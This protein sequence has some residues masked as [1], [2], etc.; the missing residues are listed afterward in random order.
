MGIFARVVIDTW[1]VGASTL[2]KGER[3]IFATFAVKQPFYLRPA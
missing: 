3:Q 1:V 2:S